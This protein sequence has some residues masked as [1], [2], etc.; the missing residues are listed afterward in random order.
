VSIRGDLILKIG[1]IAD[2][3]IP[4]RALSLHPGLISALRA[5]QV[6][7]ILH[8][9]D[10]CTAAVIAELEKV[11]PVDLVRGNRDW[12]FRGK[13]G[14]VAQL[15]L[16][17]VPVALMHGHINWF[18]YLVDKWHYIREGYQLQRYLP[19]LIAAAGDARVVVF[20]HTHHPVIIHMDGR[21]FFN[22][23]SAGF[24]FR[25]NL[26]PS[27]GLLRFLSDGIVEGEIHELG[28]F[29]LEDRNWI[30]VS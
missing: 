12:A 6:E 28:G 24:G 4:D 15:N 17:G 26:N 8:A 11:A 3:H 9:G 27:W 29:R 20:G 13:N 5:A 10:I 21:L 2:T 30:P 23:G 14:W 16:A 19:R 18:R 22:P 1:V 7:R 25:R